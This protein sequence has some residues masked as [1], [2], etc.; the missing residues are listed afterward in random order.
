MNITFYKLQ[1]EINDVKK[2]KTLTAT[3][4]YDPMVVSGTLKVATSKITP[5]FE[6][7]N[8]ITYFNGYNYCYIPDFN[9][10]YFVTDVVS[11]RVGI[12]AIDMRVDVLT[13]FLTQSNISNLEGYVFRS[14]NYGNKTFYDERVPLYYKRTIREYVPTNVTSNIV[15]FSFLSSNGEVTGDGINYVFELLNKDQ[16]YTPVRNSVPT[17]TGQTTT[18]LMPKTVDGY[19]CAYNQSVVYTTT[20]NNIAQVLTK[21]IEDTTFKSNVKYITAYPF[22]PNTVGVYPTNMID[23]VYGKNNETIDYQIGGNTLHVQA[24]KVMSNSTVY[25]VIADFILQAPT[26]I[27]ENTDV[28]FT[29]LD[30]SLVSYELWLPYYGWVSIPCEYVGHRIIVYYN[31][32]YSDG[33]GTVN[34]ATFSKGSG[35][36]IGE[37]DSNCLILS[38][39]V[40]LGVKIPV[41]ASNNTELTARKQASLLNTAV[42][43]GAGALVTYAGYKTGNYRTMAYG[44]GGIAGSLVNY[45][46]T[47]IQAIDR[48]DAVVPSGDAGLYLPQQVRVRFT[49][50]AKQT[51]F[52]RSTYKHFNGYPCNTTVKLSLLSGYA[53]VDKVHLTNATEYVY[54]ITYGEEQEL[55]NLL[56]NGVYF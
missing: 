47:R 27:P 34:V 13:S 26:D 52:D 49:Y 4:T 17:I 6:F 2:T 45:A 16:Y 42:G 21:C 33:S 1:D 54:D 25:N 32:N 37:L 50:N 40:Q 19:F 36:G 46:N 14:E 3:A 41:D 22:K 12:T 38:K 18:D 39:Q 43:I 28:D 7:A 53:E 9:R 51:N 24:L 29:V 8:D 56:K 15:N 20:Q 31:I 48:A 23:V 44:I 11:V 30:R 35:T 55:N 10:Y 5:S